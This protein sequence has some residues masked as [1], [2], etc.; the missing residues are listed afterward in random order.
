MLSSSIKDVMAKVIRRERDENTVG[1]ENYRERSLLST[2]PFA[3]IRQAHLVELKE[4]LSI[5]AMEFPARRVRCT[6]V[7]AGGLLGTFL[8]HSSKVLEHHQLPDKNIKWIWHNETCDLD[9][10]S[11]ISLLL[12]RCRRTSSGKDE[13]GGGPRA[14]YARHNSEGQALHTLPSMT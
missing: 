13:T 6:T 9:G 7:S 1:T 8:I 10:V 11:S 2:W 5:L 14:D 4:T 3:A 12:R